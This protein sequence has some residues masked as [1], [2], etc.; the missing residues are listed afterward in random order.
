MEL[1]N[2]YQQLFTFNTFMSNA[3]SLIFYSHNLPSRIPQIRKVIT[4][5]KDTKRIGPTASRL[6]DE[7]LGDSDQYI[8]ILHHH[9][10]KLKSNLRLAEDKAMKEENLSTSRV[11]QAFALNNSDPSFVKVRTE[12][13]KVMSTSVIDIYGQFSELTTPILN[14]VSQIFQLNHTGFNHFHRYIFIMI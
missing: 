2:D 3:D 10:S 4:N 8:S 11:I 9:D 1:P 6:L 14:Q 12:I 5:V 13:D 7:V